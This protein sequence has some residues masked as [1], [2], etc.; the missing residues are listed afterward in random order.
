[1]GLLLQEIQKLKFAT[2]GQELL[3]NQGAPLPADKC[4]HILDPAQQNLC[5]TAVKQFLLRR[6]Q[7]VSNAD[8]V[9]LGRRDFFL[10]DLP[11]GYDDYEICPKTP[12]EAHDDCALRVAL[13]RVMRK[14]NRSER[15]MIPGKDLTAMMKTAEQVN[16]EDN[17]LAP[18]DVAQQW[19]TT[20]GIVQPVS[21]NLTDVEVRSNTFSV[22]QDGACN[23]P[24][25]RG[26][27]STFLR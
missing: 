23:P 24:K 25:G 16:V 1:M 18:K 10:G 6:L 20:F 2:A 26:D 8:V 27:G 21:K 9:M 19:L 5:E 14:E 12:A 7:L 11:E 22:P 13:D 17:G 3:D 4:D 15:V